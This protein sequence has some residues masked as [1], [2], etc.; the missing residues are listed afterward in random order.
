MF[1]T[2]TSIWDALEFGSAESVE[3]DL[4]REQLRAEE[5]E[6]SRRRANQIALL[7]RADRLQLDTAD[8][9]RTMTD[10]VVS[11]LDV[12]PQTAHRLAH[13][14]S[15]D[16]ADIEEQITAGVYGLDRASFLCQLRELGGPEQVI[17][18]SLQYSLG[19]L[20]GLIDRLRRI[21]TADEQTSFD[22]RYMVSQPSLDQMGGRFWGQTHGTDWETITRALH[23]RESQLPALPDQTRGQRT[24]DALASICLDSL[25]TTTG[26]E[27]GRAMTVAEVFVDAA[28]TAATSGEKGVT[29]SSGPRV[30]P[31]TLA[32]I[33]CTG[34]IRVIMQG[35]DGRPIGVSD[36]GEAIPPAVRAYVLHRDLGQC[37]VDCESRYRLQPHHVKPRAQGGDHD[38]D[39]LVTLCWYHH[40][41]AIHMLGMIIDPDSPPHRRKLTW[42]NP[43]GPPKRAP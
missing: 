17:T 21:N 32:E 18:D 35:E 28:L 5:A 36:L 11:V 31:N 3:A 30:G 34:K 15:S 8:G 37:Q 6:I 20:Y 41:V 25:T 39:N 13:V 24:V 10:W 29:L 12:S 38:P 43:H 7:R 22:E 23:H 9:S 14:A 26:G 33:L 2:D 16:Q 40:H 4:I 27:T 42:P 1:A 19:Y